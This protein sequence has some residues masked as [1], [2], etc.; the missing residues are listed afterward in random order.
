MALKP[1]NVPQFGLAKIGMASTNPHH[2]AF[3]SYT[4]HICC[5][6]C[7]LLSFISM[8]VW[9]IDQ[10]ACKLECDLKKTTDRCI[11]L[12]ITYCFSTDGALQG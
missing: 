6:D 7:Y 8:T 12:L 3:D 11:K 10:Q 1:K 9:V 2:K 4:H 5:Y